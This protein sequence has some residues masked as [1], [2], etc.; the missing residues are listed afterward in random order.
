MADVC[1][2]KDYIKTIDTATGLETVEEFELGLEEVWERKCSS[3]S[4]VD[5]VSLINRSCYLAAGSVSSRLH[6]EFYTWIR[7]TT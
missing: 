3:D 2:W 7:R 4:G 1:T 5:E 6:K